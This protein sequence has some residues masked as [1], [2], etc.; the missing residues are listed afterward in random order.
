MRGLRFLAMLSL[1][2]P[3]CFAVLAAAGVNIGKVF[4]K[5]ATDT[6]PLLR[7]QRDVLCQYV[8]CTGWLIGFACDIGGTIFMVVALSLAPV[9]VIEPVA[10]SGLAILALFCH[11]YLRERLRCRQWIGIGFAMSGVIGLGLIASPSNNPMSTGA[12]LPLLVFLMG[13]QVALEICHPENP[14]R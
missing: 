4:Q 11:C 14:A 7:L 6:L 9:S 3:I 12:I 2:L 10:G 5:E 8:K 13:V 1:A